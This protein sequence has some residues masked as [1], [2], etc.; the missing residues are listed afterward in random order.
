MAK[1]AEDTA[2]RRVVLGEV[3]LLSLFG[4]YDA[5]RKALEEAYGVSLISRDGSVAIA[6]PPEAVDAAEADRSYVIETPYERPAALPTGLP[7]GVFD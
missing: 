2:T 7:L 1:S 6:G 4:P 5:E 3:D